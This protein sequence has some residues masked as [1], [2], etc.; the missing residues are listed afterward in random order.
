MSDFTPKLPSEVPRAPDPTDFTLGGY[1]GPSHAIEG[2]S[3]W[4]RVAARLIDIVVLMLL[5][6]LAGAVFGAVLTIVA[7]ATGHPVGLVIAK[8]RAAGV[9][10]SF[11][12]SWQVW[13]TTQFAKG[14]MGVRSE[15]WRY[16]W[17][18]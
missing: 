9:A 15:S 6:S 1:T 7:I 12:A 17:S 8:H 18:S 5:A 2:V 16:K 10:F 4:P 11:A 13:R 14:C 3:F